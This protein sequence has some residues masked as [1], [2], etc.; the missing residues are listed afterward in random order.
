MT[1]PEQHAL[2][3]WPP[4]PIPS[5]RNCRQSNRVLDE[6]EDQWV[7]DF[8]KRLDYAIGDIDRN[9]P[10]LSIRTA[11]ACSVAIPKRPHLNLTHW[12][13]C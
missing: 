13:F 3:P 5:N 10:V 1:I 7:N 4:A 8:I 11:P 12:P 6:S 2:T 9:K